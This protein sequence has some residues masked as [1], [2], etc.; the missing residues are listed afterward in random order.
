[1]T[2]P[3]P[4]VFDEDRYWVTPESHDARSL[5]LPRHNLSLEQSYITTILLGKYLSSP[6]TSEGNSPQ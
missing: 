6:E 5:P 1:M 2:H 3:I 4:I